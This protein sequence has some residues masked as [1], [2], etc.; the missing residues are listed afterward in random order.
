MNTE[1]RTCTKYKPILLSIGYS[2]YHWCHVM[3]HGF[4]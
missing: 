4:F 1:P 3:A 2:A